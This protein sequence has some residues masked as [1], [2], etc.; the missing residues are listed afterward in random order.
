[1]GRK[2]MLRIGTAQRI[3]RPGHGHPF[4]V[5][6]RHHSTTQTAINQIRKFHAYITPISKRMGAQPVDGQNDQCRI[7]CNL[8]I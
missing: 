8:R 6:C 4:E 5:K 1:M 3:K 2:E 7:N